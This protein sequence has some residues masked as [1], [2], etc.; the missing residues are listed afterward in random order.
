MLRFNAD[1]ENLLRDV[2]FFGRPNLTFFFII[3]LRDFTIVAT[4]GNECENKQEMLLKKKNLMQKAGNKN[5]IYEKLLKKL[6][7]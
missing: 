3:L 7:Y 5:S 4:R 2:C 1:A 6:V